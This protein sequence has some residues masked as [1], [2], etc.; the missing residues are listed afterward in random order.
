MFCW[1][2]GLANRH[3]DVGA[4]R[5]S[6]QE[7]PTFCQQAVTM[8]FGAAVTGSGSAAVVCARACFGSARVHHV[9]HS[10]KARPMVRGQ[11]NVQESV[12]ILGPQ[13]GRSPG[14]TERMTTK[15]ARHFMDHVSVGRSFDGLTEIPTETA[16]Q[17]EW[18]PMGADWCADLYRITMVGRDGL[19]VCR[20]GKQHALEAGRRTRCHI[21]HQPYPAILKQ[22]PKRHAHDCQPQSN[23][24]TQARTRI[25]PKVSTAFSNGKR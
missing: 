15:R 20:R 16:C 10:A 13:S 23:I 2:H 1:R 4:Q 3:M 8:R 5:V 21:N 9:W 6:R 12:I 11:K 7:F 18:S 19:H 14:A 25:M 17:R 22:L 24:Q